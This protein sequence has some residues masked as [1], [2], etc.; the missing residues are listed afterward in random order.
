MAAGGLEQWLE[1]CKDAGG[2]RKKEKSEWQPPKPSPTFAFNNEVLRVCETDAARLAPGVKTAR[3]GHKKQAQKNPTQ[4]TRQA[5]HTVRSV[6][7]T[8]VTE[9]RKRCSFWLNWKKETKL[10][11][12]TFWHSLKKQKSLNEPKI[13]T[14]CYVQDPLR[15]VSTWPHH[16]F[17]QSG[18]RMKFKLVERNVVWSK[19]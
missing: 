16:S 8:S 4:F 13:K 6:K 14:Q 12:K 5:V 17:W 11:Q 10:G 3:P 7:V 18:L 2:G 9:F 15:S 1:H 19:R